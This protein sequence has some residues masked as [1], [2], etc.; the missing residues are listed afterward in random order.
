[1]VHIGGGSEGAGGASTPPTFRM[2]AL[3]TVI[4]IMYVTIIVCDSFLTTGIIACDSFLATG[5][6]YITVYHTA[7]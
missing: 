4:A 3:S 2:G 5:S 1:M 7:N 6:I